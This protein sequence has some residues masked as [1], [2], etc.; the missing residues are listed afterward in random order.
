[1]QR[2]I[3]WRWHRSQAL[4]TPEGTWHH[5][6]FLSEHF[7][8]PAF[9][10]VNCFK[11]EFSLVP[12][13]DWM[14]M[15][16]TH[17]PNDGTYRYPKLGDYERAFNGIENLFSCDSPIHTLWSE[18]E[19]NF[20]PK[21]FWHA[22]A[23]VS[24]TVLVSMVTRAQW[25]DTS[26][27]IKYQIHFRPARFGWPLIDLWAICLQMLVPVIWQSRPHCIT[28]HWINNSNDDTMWKLKRGQQMTSDKCKRHDCV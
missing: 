18:L 20:V 13:L 26:R 9:Q 22:S 17:V 25:L 1:M 12:F 11:Y 4:D 19:N 15:T 2:K 8:N 5:L 28:F 3:T 21:S 6:S 14:A 10:A 7:L 24:D 27:V 23:E 16:V